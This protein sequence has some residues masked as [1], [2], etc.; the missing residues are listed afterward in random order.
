MWILKKIPHTRNIHGNNH[1]HIFFSKQ[2]QPDPWFHLFLYYSKVLASVTFLLSSPQAAFLPWANFGDKGFTPQYLFLD[3]S[4]PQ[5][6]QHEWSNM[7]KLLHL[8]LQNCTLNFFHS[9]LSSA[10]KVHKP[11]SWSPT[12]IANWKERFDFA[13]AEETVWFIQRITSW[14]VT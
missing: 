6:N 14:G 12:I 13:A 8:H 2:L 9:S 7:V 4:K 11:L 5:R 1:I 10:R 3:S